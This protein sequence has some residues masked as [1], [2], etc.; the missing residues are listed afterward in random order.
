MKIWSWKTQKLKFYSKHD[1][2][3]ESVISKQVIEII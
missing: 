3:E 2:A 1:Q